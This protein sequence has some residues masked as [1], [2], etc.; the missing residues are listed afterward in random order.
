MA[1]PEPRTLEVLRTTPITPHMQRI[2]LGGA[3]LAGFP[4]D[5]ASAYIKLAFPAEG[6][7]PMTRTYTVRHHRA[8]EIDVDFVLHDTA[9]PA[10]TW[11]ATARPG[12]RIRVGGPGPR[13]LIQPDADWFLLAGDMTALPAIS[14]NLELLPDDARGY[15][16]IEVIDE[17][18]IQSLAR[19]EHVDVQWIINPEPDPTGG[20]LVDHIRQLHWPDGQPA[21]WAACEFS[22]MRKLRHYFKQERNVP[23]THLY[24]SSYWKMGSSEDQHK[25]AKRADAE[26]DGA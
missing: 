17:S 25:L 4:D 19:P 22:G 20:T 7:R 23:K 10:S 21:V 15:A 8:G 9:G 5:Q 24:I 18:D 11:A 16:V 2:T 12:D 6:D 1:R 13:K 3:G 14:V 26:K